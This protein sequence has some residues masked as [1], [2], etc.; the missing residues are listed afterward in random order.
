MPYIPKNKNLDSINRGTLKGFKRYMLAN[1]YYYRDIFGDITI[2][3]AWKQVRKIQ[4][5]FSPEEFKNGGD[6]YKSLRGDD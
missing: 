2:E 6:F 1:P 5:S 3:E 4:K